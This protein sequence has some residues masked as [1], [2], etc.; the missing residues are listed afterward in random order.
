MGW[1]FIPSTVTERNAKLKFIFADSFS[2]A[3]A[4]RCTDR[5]ALR[6]RHGGG[7]GCTP[8]FLQPI[9]GAGGLT[10]LNPGRDFLQ[11]LNLTFDVTELQR[12]GPTL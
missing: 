8:D 9:Q 10:A 4:R 11:P 7:S 12:L 2:G 3:A 5:E 1:Q 6:A